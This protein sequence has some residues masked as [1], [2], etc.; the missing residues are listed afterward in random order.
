MKNIEANMTLQTQF[1][2][3]EKRKKKVAEILC[4]AG[5][6]AIAK[7]PAW[8]APPQLSHRITLS[9][10]FSAADSRVDLGPRCIYRSLFMP[11]HGAIDSCVNSI[12]FLSRRE[13]RG[14]GSEGNSGLLAHNYR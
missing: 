2:A 14:L 5:L 12:S 7:A 13:R 3:Q 11:N 6:V 4:F 10:L 1:N 8:P 9:L